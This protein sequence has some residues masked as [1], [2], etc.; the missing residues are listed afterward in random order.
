MNNNFAKS[1]KMEIKNTFTTKE[2]KILNNIANKLKFIKDGDMGFFCEIFSGVGMIKSECYCG[3]I[4][5][6]LAESS[7]SGSFY[8]KCI[9]AGKLKFQVNNRD[10]TFTKKEFIFMN[11]C[12]DKIDKANLKG[13]WWKFYKTPI[14]NYL[15]FGKITTSRKRDCS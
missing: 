10:I 3:Y 7:S 2:K 6:S 5:H 9:G 1:R 4:R 14:R 13:F 8:I 12:A 15:R 11:E